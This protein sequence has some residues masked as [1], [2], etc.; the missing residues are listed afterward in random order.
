M[1]LGDS[2]KRTPGIGLKLLR[3]RQDMGSPLLVVALLI[4]WFSS[5][6]ANLNRFLGRACDGPADDLVGV[7]TG[8][9]WSQL[10][11]CVR[12][13]FTRQVAAEPTRETAAFWPVPIDAAAHANTSQ[14]LA[15][16]LELLAHHQHH[17]VAQG[18]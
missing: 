18:A 7:D 13:Q 4:F 17:M 16:W 12:R 11:K 1:P 10:W 5:P 15:Q 2:V 3:N 8:H 9:S 14:S 6:T